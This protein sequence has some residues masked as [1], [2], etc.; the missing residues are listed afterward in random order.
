MNSG[1]GFIGYGSM[2]SMRVKG[3]LDKKC[4]GI[5]I[6]SSAP[7]ILQH[8]SAVSIRA[9]QETEDLFH[10]LDTVE[11]IYWENFEIAPVLTS[12]SPDLIALLIEEFA[13]A[14]ARFSTL[15]PEQA[16]R[17]IIPTLSGISQPS[18]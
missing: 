9:E 8:S 4:L 5:K 18:R 16:Q 3:L 7:G 17:L 1:T 11:V 14:A 12:C 15:L 6:F 2:G 13:R 10:A